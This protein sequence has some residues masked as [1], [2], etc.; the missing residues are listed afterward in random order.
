MFVCVHALAALGIVAAGVHLG[1]YSG[2]AG[3][4]FAFLTAVL[5]VAVIVAALGD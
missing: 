1:V 5:T 2:P 3:P 4:M